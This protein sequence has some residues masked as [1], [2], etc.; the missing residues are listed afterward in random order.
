VCRAGEI[1]GALFQQIIGAFDIEDIALTTD[2]YSAVAA[3]DAAIAKS[4]TSTVE[5][6]ILGTPFVVMYKTGMVN[7]QIG[8]RLVKTP[9]LA[10]VNLIAERPII[11]EFI[12]HD[13]IPETITPVV[14]RLLTDDTYFQQMKTNL[15]E[16]R[17]KIGPPGGAAAAAQIFTRWLESRDQ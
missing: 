8:R 1:S 5:C 10:M 17:E 2:T 7:Y 16:V 12:Q 4:G 15:A 14:T 9:Y 13:A 11:P 3:A 6:A